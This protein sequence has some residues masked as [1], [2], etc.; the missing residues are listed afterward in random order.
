M[1]KAMDP[2]HEKRE[3][4]ISLLK[5]EGRLAVAFSGG[6]DS[7]FLL[8][9]AKEALGE[10]LLAVTGS[11]ASFPER[12]LIGAEKLCAGMGVSF[13]S[14]GIDQLS[15]PGFAAN[16]PDRCYICK[17]A[18][19]TRLIGAANE[20]GFGAIAEGSNAD[21]DPAGRPGMRAIA[22]LGVLSPLRQAGLT[23]AEIR[24]LSKEMGLPTWSRPAYAC[25]ATRIPY[26]EEV[27]A[28]KL[29]MIGGAEEYLFGLGLEQMR[30]RMAGSTARIEVEREHFSE[31]IKPETAEGVVK[32]FRELGFKFVS[33]DIEGY[34]SG[35]MDRTL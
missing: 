14:V 3:K 22:E 33:L 26:G 18:L 30:V 32:R 23:K 31:L 20:R 1:S 9:A 16:P 29:C 24:A 25:L 6:V 7:A 2:L 34:R 19:F 4:L 21:D 15:I 13:V 12:E 5:N 8:A 27:T 28:Q 11:F 35:S 10:E 17:K